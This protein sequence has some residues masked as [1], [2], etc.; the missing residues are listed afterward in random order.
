MHVQDQ[1]TTSSSQWAPLFDKE[2]ILPR[3]SRQGHLWILPIVWAALSVRSYRNLTLWTKFFMLSKQTLFWYWEH[4]LIATVVHTTAYVHEWTGWASKSICCRIGL[5]GPWVDS[6]AVRYAFVTTKAKNTQPNVHRP[7]MEIGWNR[8]GYPSEVDW[9]RERTS[10]SDNAINNSRHL[11]ANT[12]NECSRLNTP[13][14]PHTG[15]SYSLYYSMRSL[16]GGLQQD[17]VS[18]FVN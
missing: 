18:A 7:S 16:E 12:T 15:Y 17:R 11:V 1:M 14:P 2:S 5:L 3:I 13:T 6:R 4:T 10:H 8:K 9:D